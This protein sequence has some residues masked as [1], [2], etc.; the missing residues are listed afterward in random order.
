MHLRAKGLRQRA[1]DRPLTPFPSEPWR[2]G[3]PALADLW[4]G[5][6]RGR[7]MLKRPLAPPALRAKAEVSLLRRSVCPRKVLLPPIATT[8][9]AFSSLLCSSSS[10]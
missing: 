5:R 3:T 4:W 9:C 10:V 8:P 7:S 2:A 1:L 6:P